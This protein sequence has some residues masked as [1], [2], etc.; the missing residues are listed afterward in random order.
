MAKGMS[1]EDTIHYIH[2]MNWIQ[3]V[4]GIDIYIYDYPIESERNY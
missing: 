1:G 2:S 4:Y 3:E